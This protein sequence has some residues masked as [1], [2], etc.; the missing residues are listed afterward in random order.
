MRYFDYDNEGDDEKDDIDNFFGEN[1]E[2]DFQFIDL[3]DDLEKLRL[4]QKM[5]KFII[6]TL[7]KSFFWKFKSNKT[8]ID[9]IAEMYL[10]FS[11]LTKEEEE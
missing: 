4:N 3:G 6:K 10:V 1:S 5:L 11:K 8:K 2:K 7:E 9:E